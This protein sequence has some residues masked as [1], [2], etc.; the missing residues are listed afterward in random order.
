[1]TAKIKASLYGLDPVLVCAVI[2]QESNWEPWAI[3]YEPAFYDRYITSMT[4]IGETERRARAFS[5]V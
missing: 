2:E 1:M 3:R 5:G 4:A